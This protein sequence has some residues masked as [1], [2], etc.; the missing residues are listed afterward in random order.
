M[1]P[2][3]GYGS[4]Y[5]GRS[6]NYHSNIALLQIPWN[7]PSYLYYPGAIYEGHE[8]TD[9]LPGVSGISSSE[10][11]TS[12]AKS[13]FVGGSGYVLPSLSDVDGGG[14]ARHCGRWEGVPESK[15]YFPTLVAEGAMNTT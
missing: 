7:P 12:K 14:L 1:L 13:E 8:T 9:H 11:T 10:Y 2:S 6:H 3:P 4:G 15:G 5:D